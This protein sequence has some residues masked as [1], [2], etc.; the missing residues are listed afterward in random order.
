MAAKIIDG[1]IAISDLRL[2]AYHGFYDSEREHGQMFALDIRISADIDYA[3]MRDDLARSVDYG[4]V[5]KLAVDVFCKT[6][7]RLIEAAAYAVGDALLNGFPQI[8]RLTIRVR[9]LAPP[10]PHQ[11]DSVSVEL[12]LARD[13]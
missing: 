4:K 7:H 9:K 3:A 10:I 13:G 1:K 2:H 11:M 6:Q 8:R 5:T 12:D